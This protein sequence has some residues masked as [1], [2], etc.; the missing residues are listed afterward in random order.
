MAISLQKCGFHGCEKVL[1][2][3]VYLK[4]HQ[5]RHTG[6]KPYCC[7]FGTCSYAAYTFNEVKQHVAVHS[8]RERRFVCSWVG[9]LFRTHQGSNLM[10]HLND[11]HFKLKPFKCTFSRCNFSAGRAATVRKHALTIHGGTIHHKC[12]FRGCGRTFFRSG[13]LLRHQTIMKHRHEPPKSSSNMNHHHARPDARCRWSH[14]QKR[15]RANR[16]KLCTLTGK[17]QLQFHVT[18]ADFPKARAIVLP[19]ELTD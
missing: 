16:A 12:N 6:E 11:V 7:T 2:K 13:N 1:R 18:F 17:S 10:R 5:Q 9:C 8:T 4:R 15:G 3:G 14:V 19:A